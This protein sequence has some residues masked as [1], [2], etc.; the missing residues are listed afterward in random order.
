MTKKNMLK[1]DDMS[2]ESHNCQGH[3]PLLMIDKPLDELG[4]AMIFAKLVYAHATLK[5]AFSPTT[6]TRR[7]FTLMPT[8]LNSFL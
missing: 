5:S 4:G 2:S 6:L 3:V 1:I 8:I 7:G